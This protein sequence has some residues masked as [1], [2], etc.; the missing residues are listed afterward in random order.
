MLVT[1][2]KEGETKLGDIEGGRE[3]AEGSRT[4]SLVPSLCMWQGPQAAV[5]GPQYLKP[6]NR[7]KPPKVQPPL[8]LRPARLVFHQKDPSS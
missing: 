1:G 4:E 8:A 2:I 7:P 6:H 5:H 3:T